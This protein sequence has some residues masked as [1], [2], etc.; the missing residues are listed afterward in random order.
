MNKKLV[1]GFLATSI[2]LSGVSNAL[3]AN[4]ADVKPMSINL[5]AVSELTLTEETPLFNNAN[6]YSKTGATVSPQTVDVVDQDGDWYKIKTWL[7]DKWILVDGFGVPLSSSSYT[8]TSPYGE[9]TDPITGKV[10]KHNG[11][12]VSS[13]K[14]DI[15]ASASGTVAYIGYQ[16][17]RGNYVDIEHKIN[18]TTYTTRYQHLASDSVS[19]GQKVLAGDK[20]GVMGA[21]GKATNIHLHFELLKGSTPIDPEDW[22]DF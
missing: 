4:L 14:T 12:D 15:L 11:I 18:G 19:E 13:S 10:A 5:A 2:A 21:T 17:E 22:I 20:I 9:R 6:F 3:A 16:S 8:V 7:G 1:V